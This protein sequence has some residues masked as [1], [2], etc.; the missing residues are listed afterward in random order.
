MALLNFFL[1]FNNNKDFLNE[2]SVIYIV[3]FWYPSVKILYNIV[4]YVGHKEQLIEFCLKFS[5]LFFLNFFW[6]VKITHIT[7]YI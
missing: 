5:F 2:H 4:K 6:R 1:P 7:I 3:I